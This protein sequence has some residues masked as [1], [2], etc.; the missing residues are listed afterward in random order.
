MDTG[1]TA[2]HLKHWAGAKGFA[3]GEAYFQE[4]RVRN[5]REQDGE[6]T[7][8]AKG[9]RV[10]HV[11]L[12]SEDEQIVL[13]CDCPVGQ[14]GEFCKHGVAVGLAW[15]QE[16]SGESGATRPGKATLAEADPGQTEL[17]EWLLSRDKAVLVDWL[18]DVA[19]YDEH[20]ENRLTLKA[21]LARGF[22]KATYKKAVSRGL[23]VRGYI[24]YHRMPEYF[25]R[26]DAAIDSVEDLF[27]HGHAEAVI[28]LSEYALKRVESAIERVD[29]SDGFMSELIRRLEGLHLRACREARPDPKALA[30]RL[31]GRAL[32]AHW[33]V[34]QDAIERY[35][36]VLGEPGQAVYRKLAEAEWAKV[37]P[38]R[39]GERGRGFFHDE[40]RSNITRIMEKLAR[41]DE[42]VDAWVRVAERDLS[43]SQRFH[44]IAEYYLK[45]KRTEQALAWAEKGMK[46]FG[47]ESDMRLLD[48]LA[49]LYHRDKRH[50]EAMALVWSLFEEHPGLGRYQALRKNA[51]RCKQWPEWRERALAYLRACLDKKAKSPSRDS[52]GHT[53]NVDHS[54]LVSIFLWEK[55]VEAAW[56]EAEAG[57]CN[58]ELWLELAALREKKHPRDTIAVYRKQIAPILEETNNEAYAR[59]IEL[60]RRLEKLMKRVKDKAGFQAYLDELRKTYKRKRNFMKMLAEV[61][62]WR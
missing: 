54:V 16:Q 22:D 52:W 5:L 37:E 10:Y 2:K 62:S 20:L 45:A 25:K 36:E 48:L 11:S 1:F 40:H 24:D 6:I 42:D 41:R 9:A 53:R 51:E 46:T 47:E 59:A 18:L 14:R 15:L 27:E 50:E 32:N 35:A 13:A 28:E 31:F 21:T 7:A 12:K 23:G 38:I 44:L 56:R 4:D 19:R 29:D 60:L 30:K 49:D 39:P 57:G 8:T 3:R 33:G 43:T 61:D 58:N 34:F 26:A 55:D 17:R